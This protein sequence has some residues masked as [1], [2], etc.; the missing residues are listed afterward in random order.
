MF[1]FWRPIVI[2][3]F[4]P[5]PGSRDRHKEETDVD[6]A[7]GVVTSLVPTT[8][9][10]DCLPTLSWV[11]FRERTAVTGDARPLAGVDG[12]APVPNNVELR[13]TPED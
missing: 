6:W 3:Y 11:R 10:A 4:I 8:K 2:H 5:K 1:V 9:I 12:E 7:R 13:A